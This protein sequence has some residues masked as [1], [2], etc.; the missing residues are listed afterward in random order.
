M[1]SE[2]LRALSDELATL[3]KRGLIMEPVAIAVI[4]DLV[5]ELADNAET[6]EQRANSPVVFRVIEG[7]C[8]GSRT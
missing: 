6:L 5:G 4:G 3:A 8:D 1:L 7:G 2:S